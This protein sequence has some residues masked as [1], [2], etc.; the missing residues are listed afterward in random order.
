MRS[1]FQRN[2]SGS[3]FALLAMTTLTPVV[4]ASADKRVAISAGLRRRDSPKPGDYA[5]SC[6][7][8]PTP[9]YHLVVNS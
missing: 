2:L 7:L 8:N 9:D 5:Y 4:V 3:A 6:L 1:R